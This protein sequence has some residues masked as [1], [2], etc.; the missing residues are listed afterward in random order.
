MPDFPKKEAKHLV[1]P[2]FIAT[3]EQ[4]QQGE[5]LYLRYCSASSGCGDKPVGGGTIPGL[6][7]SRPEI[8]NMFT[9]YCYLRKVLGKRDA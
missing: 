8:F 3:Q 4:L 5:N 6:N 9:Q 7:Y 1:S 2:D